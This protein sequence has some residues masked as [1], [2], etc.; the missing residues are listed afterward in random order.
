MITVKVSHGS[1]QHEISVPAQS[2]FGNSRIPSTMFSAVVFFDLNGVYLMG[3]EVGELKRLLS[4][5]TG[6][7]PKG[8]RLL[9]RGKEKEDEE[10]LHRAGVKDMSKLILL[11]N[12]A[13]KDIEIKEMEPKNDGPACKETDLGEMK[14]DN[15]DPISE[16][17]MTHK[18]DPAGVEMKLE[19]TKLDKEIFK[20]WEAISKV[21]GD[22][23]KLA[24]K[25]FFIES[26]VQSGTIVQEKEII[27]LT[28]L[29]MV[30]LLKLDGIKAEG[31]AKMRRRNEVGS[32]PRKKL[33]ASEVMDI[34][35]SVSGNLGLYR[36]I[37][38]STLGRIPGVGARFGVFELMSAFYKDGREDN[39]I[40]VSEAFLGGITAGFVESFISTP[41]ELIKLR[42]QVY[43]ASRLTATPSTTTSHVTPTSTFVARL[44]RGY[45]PH[46]NVWD[47]TLGLLSTLPTKHSNM[48]GAL[49]EYPWM[50]TGSGKPPAVYEVRKPLHIISLEGYH[51]LWRGLRP[52]IVRD[53]VFGGMFFSCWQFLHLEMLHWK[54]MAMDPPPRYYEEI[55]PVS[56]FA[57]S[58]AAGVS[59]SIAAAASHVFDTA[60]S[61]SQCTVTPKYVSM[62][63]S[64]IKWKQPGYWFE[65]FA[66]IQPLDRNLLFRGISLRMARSGFASFA[67]VGSYFFAIDHLI[68]R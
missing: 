13:S 65:R 6:L 19:Q 29:L 66:G 12:P 10:C 16:E 25:V 51:A 57:S 59:G 48:V 56:P 55:G 40:D 26:A 9:F 34:V 11:E 44:L 32:D 15:E 21:K 45:S 18:E 52:T 37:G 54:S 42:E 4:G 50:L 43:G 28:E 38:W 41:F 68:A 36:G 53:C 60:K 7:D 46:K 27:M 5:V 14:T 22:V 31:E 33:K 64:L 35:R 8:L 67:I 30:Q 61:R 24:E 2:T 63:W 1:S 3:F 17:T 49:R 23:D 47:C 58:L 39:Y 62:E 20:A